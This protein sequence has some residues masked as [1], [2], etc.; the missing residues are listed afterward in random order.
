MTLIDRM[1][2]NAVIWA[3]RQKKGNRTHAAK[4]LGISVRTLRNW[5]KKFKIEGHIP[6]YN[7]TH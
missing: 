6:D 2:R 4:L 7:K 5:I 1:H 3:L